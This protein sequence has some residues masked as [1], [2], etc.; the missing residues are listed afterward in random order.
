VNKAVEAL[1]SALVAR[2][3]MSWLVKVS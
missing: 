1:P 2:T 3:T